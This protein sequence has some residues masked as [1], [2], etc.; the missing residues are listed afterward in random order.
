ML[1]YFRPGRVATDPSQPWVDVRQTT[2]SLPSRSSA[3]SGSISPR[4]D[5]SGEISTRAPGC[6]S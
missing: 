5:H 3:T 6:Q 2:S 4:A 1:K